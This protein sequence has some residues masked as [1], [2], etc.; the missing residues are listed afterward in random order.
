MDPRNALSEAAHIVLTS[1]AGID[2]QDGFGLDNHIVGAIEALG[3]SVRADMHDP[4]VIFLIGPDGAEA[5]VGWDESN[6]KPRI[7]TC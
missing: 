5:A 6:P 3:V 2:P 4:L 1:L 7:W